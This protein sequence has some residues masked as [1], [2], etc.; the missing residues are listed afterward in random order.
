MLKSSWCMSIAGH[1]T[2]GFFHCGWHLVDEIQDRTVLQIQ[3][4]IQNCH[5]FLRVLK[6]KETNEH[7]LSMG[8]GNRRSAFG[9]S[10][11]LELLFEHCRFKTWRLILY[12][13]DKPRRNLIGLLLIRTNLTK[14]L[15]SASRP[16]S[17]KTT[18]STLY[19]SVLYFGG[20]SCRWS[21]TLTLL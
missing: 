21:G 10:T 15:S 20:V 12:M 9:S 5:E 18:R 2:Q 4:V 14:S 8:T 3:R 6:V 7:N 19:D 11:E 16:C 1:G 17:R 13:S